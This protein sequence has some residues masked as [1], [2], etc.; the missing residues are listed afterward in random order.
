MLDHL[1]VREQ[2]LPGSDKSDQAAISYMLRI[3]DGY[4]QIED[5]IVALVKVFKENVKGFQ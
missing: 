4:Y 3:V 5:L 2:I 1:E